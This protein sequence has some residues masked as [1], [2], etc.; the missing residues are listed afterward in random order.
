ME[1][2][3]VIILGQFSAV[4]HKKIVLSTHL[5]IKVP[6]L[7]TPQDT[8]LWRFRNKKKVSKNYHQILLLNK[9]SPDID[10]NDYGNFCV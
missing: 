5:I 8:F 6:L 4:L 10:G 7:S 3:L 2:Y 9:S 1:E